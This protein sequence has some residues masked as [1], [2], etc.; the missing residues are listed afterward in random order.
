MDA[1][2]PWVR[3]AALAVTA[4]VIYIVCAIAVALFPDGTLA[5]FNTWVHGMDL[6]LVKRPAAKPL[7]AEEW[8]YGLVS[9]VLASYLA[10]ALYGWVRNLF[11]A[12]QGGR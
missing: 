4:G 7:T 8:I 5:F 6:T 10:G 12:M 9:I 3:G 11:S 2:K 1:T